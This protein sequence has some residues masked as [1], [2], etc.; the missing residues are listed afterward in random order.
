MHIGTGKAVNTPRTAGTM[1]IL[2]TILTEMGSH[3]HTP[4][5]N[6]PGTQWFVQGILV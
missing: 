2:T 4:V 3:V 1:Q 6:K 5:D